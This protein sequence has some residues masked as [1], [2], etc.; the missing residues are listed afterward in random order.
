MQI[1]K[2]NIIDQHSSIMGKFE[3]NHYTR[4]EG[5]FSGELIGGS[6][7]ELVV[8]QNAVIEG[9]IIGHTIIIDGYVRGDIYAS[10]KIV[11]SGSG[12]MIG[13]L[14]APSVE[15]QFGSLFD[16]KCIMESQLPINTKNTQTN[17]QVVT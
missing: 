14:F 6:E 16:G 1:N 15:I 8:S 5:K 3:F 9:K 10:N 11:V 4:F 7:S 17:T 2:V 12:R 13:N